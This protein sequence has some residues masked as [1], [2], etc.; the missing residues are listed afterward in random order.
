MTELQKQVEQRIRAEEA[1]RSASLYA[2]GLL[3]ASLDPLV[4][5]SPEGK[6]TDVNGATEIAVTGISRERLIGSDFSNYFTEPLKSQTKDIKRCMS[7]GICKRLSAHHSAHV[8]P[9]NR[10]PV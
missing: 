3:E 6:I 1:F 8:R 9:Y 4:T 7:E 2:R 5:I 10:C